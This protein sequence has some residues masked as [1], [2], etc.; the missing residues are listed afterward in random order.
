MGQVEALLWAIIGG[1]ALGSGLL[2]AWVIYLVSR[3]RKD[4]EQIEAE[5]R[6][7]KEQQKAEAERQLDEHIKML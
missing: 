5:A 3:P 4:T 1:I 2:F 6:N 7:W